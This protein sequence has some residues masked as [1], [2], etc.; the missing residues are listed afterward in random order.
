MYK[1]I[2][3]LLTLSLTIFLL[4]PSA[5]AWR[6]VR[7]GQKNFERAWQAYTYLQQDKAVEYFKTSADAYAKALAADPPSRTARFASTLAMAGISFYYAGRYA[8]CIEAMETAH[9]KEKRIWEANLFIGLSHARLGEKAKA[10]ESLN[11]YLESLPSQRILSNSVTEQIK[12]IEGDSTSLADA[13]DH[14]DKATTSQ[15]VD[16]INFNHSPR[17]SNP[18]IERCSGTYWWRN[19]RAPCES[20]GYGLNSA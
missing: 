9:R 2:A 15:F 12:D 5:F 4:T 8:E 6:S 18:S 3:I 1:K 16:N 10:I 17:T 19:N 20:T 13:A 14:I 11:A 7:T